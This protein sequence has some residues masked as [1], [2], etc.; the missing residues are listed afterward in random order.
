MKY[1]VAF[2]KPTKDNKGSA[3]FFEADTDKQSVFLSM[4][5]QAGGD[6]NDRK[7]DR[8]R[9]I[10]M[11]L[12]LSDLGAIITLLNGRVPGLGNKGDNGWTGLYHKNQTGFSSLSMVEKEKGDGYWMSLTVDKGGNK[13]KLGLGLTLGEA[14]QLLMFIRTI[15]P[16]LFEDRYQAGGSSNST[17]SKSTQNTSSKPTAATS[18]TVSKKPVEVDEEIPI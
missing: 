9:R 6:E 18:K 3:A 15:L 13:S 14:E 12:G 8:D 2:W 4:T 11:S 16:Y 17:S 5:P 7:F 1:Q 10:V